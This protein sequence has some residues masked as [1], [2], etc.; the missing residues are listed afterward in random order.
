MISNK[1]AASAKPRPDIN[2]DDTVQTIWIEIGNHDLIIG[3]IYRRARSSADLEKGEF[4]QLSN[5]ILKAAST[6]MKVLLLDDTNID[7]N[8]P[9]HK[10]ANEAEAL[11]SDLEAVNMRRLPCSVPTWKSYG[12][13][14]VCP[15]PKS[16][17]CDCLKS[18]LTKVTSSYNLPLVR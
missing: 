5:Q 18:H 8:N 17:A 3:G 4:A 15:C 2:G 14:K 11:L 10:K 12:R 16:V 1:L 7:H 13:H 6:G 9:K